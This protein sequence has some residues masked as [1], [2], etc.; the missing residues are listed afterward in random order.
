MLVGGK[1]SPSPLPTPSGSPQ[2]F[3]ALEVVLRLWHCG[4]MAMGEPNGAGGPGPHGRKVGLRASF[5][6]FGVQEM[7]QATGRM[8]QSKSQAQRE[9]SCSISCPRGEL[10]RCSA[11]CY[12]SP[13][14]IAVSHSMLHHNWCFGGRRG[15][16]RSQTGHWVGL[17]HHSLTKVPNS[18]RHEKAVGL[19]EVGRSHLGRLDC[20][21]GV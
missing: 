20:K 21:T 17:R 5:R 8:P 12:K 15:V 14:P 11:P 10:C 4:T 7:S 1:Q 2:M 19:L 18:S 3:P 6:L 9:L 16:S 13:F